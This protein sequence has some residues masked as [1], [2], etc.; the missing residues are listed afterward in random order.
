[1]FS[2]FK[3]LSHRHRDFVTVDRHAAPLILDRERVVPEWIDYNG[4]MNLAYYVLVFDHATD[5]FLDYIGLD[6]DFRA[7]HE[8]STFTGELHLNYEKEAREGDL[9]YVSTQLLGYDEKRIHYFHQMY[10]S[11]DDSL[12]ATNELLS[13]YMD[14]RIRRVGLM[15]GK[16]IEMLAAIQDAHKCLP[17]PAQV[18]SRIG[19]GASKKRP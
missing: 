8:G 17:V 16:I 9:V 14:M 2:A 15:P 3:R 7:H 4:H 10:D 19:T 1:M 12:I 5:Q 11:R 6:S 13:L 18:G